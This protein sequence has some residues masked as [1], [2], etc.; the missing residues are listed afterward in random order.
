MKMKTDNKIQEDEA[1]IRK[2]R[3]SME[4]WKPIILHLNSILMW[5]KQW[6]PT[7]IA[8]ATTVMFMLLWLSEA[9]ILTVICLLGLTITMLDYA[10]PSVSSSIFKS[11]ITEEEQRQYDH[12]C[13]NIIFYKTKLELLFTSYYR[14]RVTNPK[15]YFSITTFALCTLAYIGSVVNNLFL[16]YLLVTFILLAPGLNQHGMLDKWTGGISKLFNDLIE[17]AK[18]RV[19]QNK[20]NQ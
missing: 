15:L 7:A 16:T 3:I 19:A 5:D 8:V 2:L 10:V 18:S 11:S 17:N 9:N 1:Q 12:I 20:K 13:T 4:N 14:M 6:H